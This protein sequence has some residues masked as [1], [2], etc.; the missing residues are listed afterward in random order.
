M[1]SDSSKYPQEIIKAIAQEIDMGMICFLNTDTMEFDSVL[2]ESYDAYWNGDHDDF[3]KE[4][5]DK[6]DGW[7]HTVRIEPP[8]S[9]Q[10]FQIME[11]FIEDCIPCK[12]PIKSRLW[13][14]IS[15]GKPFRNFKFIID[16]SQ[17][18]QHWFDFKQSQLEQFV[19]EQ[20]L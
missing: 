4:V 18:R 9:R 6:V 8:K 17:Y 5:Y 19:L 2:G 11:S 14:A 13:N 7:E 20:L 10:S 1:H 3:Y 15:R 12:A 16:N